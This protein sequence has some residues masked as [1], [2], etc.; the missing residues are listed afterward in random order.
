LRDLPLTDIET[1]NNEFEALKSVA[2]D[3]PDLIVLDINLE[4]IDGRKLAHLLK[5]I[6]CATVPIIFMSL[7]QKL[8]KNQEYSLKK[9]LSKTSFKNYLEEVLMKKNHKF[10]IAS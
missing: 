7:D 2:L 3:K 5:E 8:L 1:Y 6:N 10:F 9:P 4:V